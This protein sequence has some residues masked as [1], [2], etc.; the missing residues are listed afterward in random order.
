MVNNLVTKILFLNVRKNG[1]LEN[2]GYL[3]NGLRH[4]FIK[5]YYS[6]GNVISEGFYSNGSKYGHWKYYYESGFLSS[7]C[8]YHDGK[9]EGLR[10][11][12]YPDKNPDIMIREY[13][14]DGKRNGSWFKFYDSMDGGHVMV[15]GFYF[16]GKIITLI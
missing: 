10:E 12:F 16:N 15:K 14:K 1:K 7:I 3:K 8:N 11:K 13:Y 9:K 5:N 2:R 4:G 6:N